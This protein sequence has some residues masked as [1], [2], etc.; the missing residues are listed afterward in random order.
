MRTIY[1]F[2]VFLF[3]LPAVGSAASLRAARDFDGD[4]IQD[5]AVFHR[6]LGDFYVRRSS[7]GTLISQDYGWNETIP[8]SGDFDGD[9]L[10][11]FAVYHR[12]SGTWYIR[13]SS[14]GTQRVKQFGY[15]GTQPVPADYNGD[16]I[17]DLAVFDRKAGTWFFLLSPN[18]LFRTQ[19]WGWM[20][21][22]P[23]PADYD[24]DGDVDIAI[25][26]GNG[27]TF[28][29]RN[30]SGT[31]RQVK[32]G[33]GLTQPKTGDFNGDGTDDICV[34]DPTLADWYFLLSPANTFHK[35]RYG[36]SEANAVPGYYDA[37]N[38][39]DKAIY[40]PATGQWFIWRSITADQVVVNWGWESAR[41]VQSWAHGAPEN[42]R[43]MCIGDS[44]TF[45]VGSS[46]GGPATGYPIRLE[47]K[48]K[49]AF[50]A[51]FL[52]INEGV[53]GEITA[54]GLA[55]IDQELA[56]D[57]PDI[58]IVA[59][60]TNDMGF[61][62]IP[63]GQTGANLGAMVIR[64]QESGARTILSTIPPVINNGVF[65]R[66]NQQARI[67][68]FNP[69]IY[70]IGAMTGAAIA[71]N[72]EAITAVPNWQNTLM[73][74]VFGNHPNDAGYDVMVNT[75]FDVIAEILMSGQVY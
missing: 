60:G 20:D 59:E 19:Q 51:D 40:Y 73:E 13:R 57:N 21:T 37:D 22:Q 3:S 54:Q 35:E 5:I 56:E 11:D 71:P 27:G 25:Y 45:G 6:Q 63:S 46:S 32:F 36:F 67:V 47:R 74:F 53:S 28:Y 72:F 24:G 55:R 75:Y 69:S 15:A 7:T 2:L 34:Y 65:F 43:V 62:T 30:N 18:D 64:C 48:L 68:A 4:N 1:S 9:G 23:I 12:K 14:T 42:I 44:I 61:D 41:A 52:F 10:A 31:Q 39:T 16:G 8:V 17:T 50:G 58:A 49:G 26:H 33:W 70:A 29:I 66:G 38:T